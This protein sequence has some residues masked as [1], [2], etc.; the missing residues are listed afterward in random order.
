MGACS[1][2]RA[3]EEPRGSPRG[4]PLPA[5]T[6]P[7]PLAGRAQRAPLFR[8]AVALLGGASPKAKERRLGRIQRRG[9]VSPSDPSAGVVPF[10]E[11][12]SRSYCRAR[13]TLV[14]VLQEF[15]HEAEHIFKPP[16]VPLWRCA[17][18]C[19]DESLECTPTETRTVELQVVRVSPPLGTTLQEEMKFTEHTRCACRPRRKRLKSERSQRVAAKRRP[20][21]PSLE[22]S[23][24]VSC[25]LPDLGKEDA[26]EE[27]R[28]DAP[29]ETQAVPPLRR[30]AP[31]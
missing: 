30:A 28:A 9:L 16:C 23:A 4:P 31:L 21:Q 8:E 17:G 2:C 25:K 27:D 18:C 5:A 13:E 20:R 10:E 3:V 7:E 22:P 12:W 29:A 6:P 19:G 1:A 15:P 14:D 24:P 11:V 26:P